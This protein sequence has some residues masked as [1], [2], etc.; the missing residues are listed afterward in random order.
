MY[1]DI[2]S[3]LFM[4]HTRGDYN[5]NNVATG[6]AL[7][8]WTG[9]IKISASRSSMQRV[10]NRPIRSSAVPKHLKFEKKNK[11]RRANIFEVKSCGTGTI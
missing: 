8:P 11:L 3:L 9:I 5:R 1:Y 6:K 10:L 2:D 4:K 7:F